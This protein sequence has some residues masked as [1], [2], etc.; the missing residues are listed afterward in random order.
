M[1]E[2]QLE[3]FI[4][5]HEG[6]ATVSPMLLSDTDM[7]VLRQ[8]HR[9]GAFVQART[10]MGTGYTLIGIVD[11]PQVSSPKGQKLQTFLLVYSGEAEVPLSE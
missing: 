11:A 2:R 9:T 4:Q 10:N 5:F 7:T 8:A 6:V 3:G 1:H